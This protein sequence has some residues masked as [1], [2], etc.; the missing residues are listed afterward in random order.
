MGKYLE[1]RTKVENCVCECIFLGKGSDF[2]QVLRGWSP[3]K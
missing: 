3:P 1:S 2:H